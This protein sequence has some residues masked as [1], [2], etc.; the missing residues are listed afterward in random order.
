MVGS[1]FQSH[2]INVHFDVGGSS[3]YQTKPA[4]PYIIQAAY[5]QGGN[6]VQESSVLCEES[7][8]NPSCSFSPQSQEYSVLGWKTGFEAIKD[9]DSTFPSPPGPSTGLPQLFALN[10]KD[11]F[12]YA[13][14]AHAIAASTPLSGSAP[15]SISGVGDLPGGDFMVTLGLWRSDISAVDQVGTVLDE[16][17]TL[18]HELGHNLDLHHGGWTDTPICMP[19]YPSVMNYLYQVAGLTDSLG[20][21]HLD[22]SY[23][24]NLP[25]SED[26]LSS[27]IPMGIQQYKVRYFGPFNSNT[28]SP[29][30]N[31][32]GQAS[33]VFCSGDLPPGSISNEGK[34]VL[35]QGSAVSTPDWSNGTILPLGKLITSDLDIN[36]DGIGGETFFDSPDWLSLNLQQVSARAGADGISAD[37]GKGDLGKGDLG[38]GDLG[39]GDL[40]KGDL[41]TAALGQD[42]LGDQNFAAVVL[43]GSL[44]PPSGLAVAVTPPASTSS[45]YTGGTGNVLNWTGNTGVASQYNVY[46]CNASVSASCTPTLQTNT[47]S[48]SGNPPVVTPSYTDSVNDYVHAGS[49][50][51]S[52]ATCYNTAYN[53]YVTEVNAVGSLSSESSA[54][55]T[56]SSDVTHLFVVAN[57]QT[58][59]YGAA[60]PTPTY[61][62]YSNVASATSLNGV[63]CAY[64]PSP[65]ANTNGYYD[66]GNHP[67]T[68]TGPIV[69]TS[70]TEGVTYYSATSLALIYPANLGGTTQGITQG[71][72]TINPLPITVTAIYST[73][74]YNGT[75]A[76][77]TISASSL[78]T[79]TPTITT[80]SLVSGDTAAFTESYDNPNAASTHVMTAAGSVNDNNSGNNYKVTFVPSAATS[81]ILQATPTVTATG[82]TCTFN[83]STCAGSGTAAGVLTP[84]DY[85]TPVTL[86]YSGTSNSGA[87]YG[88]SATAPTN[89][90]NYT[91]KTSFAGDT[92]YIA[93][94]S[95]AVAIIIN[96][97]TPTVTASGNT[98]TFNGSPCAGSGS[99]TGVLTPTDTL[100]VTLS[101]SGTS[102]S[103][104][105]YG[106]SATAPTNA[107]NYTVKASFAGDTNYIAGSS[108]AV[109][110]TINKAT[111][112]VT[113][114]G[115]TCT[116][117]GS[118]CAGSGS[119]T[120]VLTP[121]DNLPVTLSYSGTSNSG[122]AYGPSGTAPTNAGSYTVTASFAGNANYIAGSSTAASITINQA[123]PTVT[124]GGPAPTA[125]DYGQPVTLT[126]TVAPPQSGETPT[127]TVTFSFT[128]SSITNY[129][130]SGGTVST[131]TPRV[132]R[133]AN[134][135]RQ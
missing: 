114:S 36:Y 2:G 48:T 54:S 77:G 110:I 131:S 59:T 21:E 62:V 46:R 23:G 89:A 15:G 9:G 24:L 41:G 118:P 92:N 7:N 57:S 113:A 76:A 30:V 12:H 63:T 67:I 126:V 127:G 106:P 53:Y 123:T 35:L 38:K 101:Y 122:A 108:T 16:A 133:P 102:N 116:F 78:T 37:L 79:A 8:A 125:P 68:C 14:F 32:A 129:I 82:N 52:T 66:A 93:G 22:Y 26:L 111:P 95:A 91:V 70:T 103:G 43:S 117:N 64:T 47:T 58:V 11:S 104:A 33:Q 90:G 128:L 81:V 80:N 84:I 25:M 60:N 121:T 124:D 112:T 27:L 105:A 19:N 3:T 10:R 61:T 69:V 20:V 87:A 88:P 134:V 31:T 100:P 107:G 39:K 135:E 1:T 98:C 56:V 18:M 109:A 115:N 42:A 97:A 94:S 73:K 132:H 55:N 34:Y 44:G 40:G 85:Q 4:S 49:T 120:G 51:P 45:T 29:E 50:C 65:S 6:P 74:V 28:N 86:S 5:A 72:L 83:G 75:T 96:K 119:A 13:L 17:G 99:A 71:S 130:C